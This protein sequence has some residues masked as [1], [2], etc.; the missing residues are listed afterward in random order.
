MAT[1][2]LKPFFVLVARFSVGENMADAVVDVKLM[3][4][5]DEI[6]TLRNELESLRARLEEVDM[7]LVSKDQILNVE[8][9]RN[10][11]LTNNNSKLESI[12]SQCRI[13]LDESQQ[14]NDTYQSTVQQLTDERSSLQVRILLR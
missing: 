3:E 9:E 13:D 4:K 5:D 6:E 12:L 14:A 8:K 10:L 2:S 11:L 7:Q 1:F